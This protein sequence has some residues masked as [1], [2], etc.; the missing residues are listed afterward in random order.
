MKTLKKSLA[1]LLALVMV[2][3]LMSVGV[4][5]ETVTL[6]DDS[7]ETDAAYV[8]QGAVAKATVNGETTYYS[9]LQEALVASWDG[10]TVDVLASVEVNEWHMNLYTE[11][12]QSSAGTATGPLDLTING[13]GNK[14]VI[15]GFDENS[16]NNGALIIRQYGSERPSI[17][18][19]N[20]WTIEVPVGSNTEG[21]GINDRAEFVN[22]TFK[23]GAYGMNLLKATG[24][25]LLQN[26]NFSGQSKAAFY[27]EDTKDLTL[28]DCTFESNFGLFTT[29]DGNI[30]VTGCY[31]KNVPGLEVSRVG[32]A[33]KGNITIRGNDLSGLKM[34]AWNGKHDTRKDFALDLSDNYWGGGAPVY[35]SGE[36]NSIDTTTGALTE[37]IIVDTYYTKKTTFEEYSAEKGW[38]E[39]SNPVS[40]KVAQVN[41][42][43]KYPTLAA[44]IAAANADDTVKLLADVN[45]AITIGKSITLDLNGHNISANGTVVNI[46]AG[47]VV[48][49]NTSDTPNDSTHNAIIPSTKGS[50]LSASGAGTTVTINA[51]YFWGRN[52]NVT[53]INATDD[54]E[55]TIIDCVSNGAPADPTLEGNAGKEGK[56]FYSGAGDEWG[57][58]KN[59]TDSNATPTK[60]PGQ[61]FVYGGT[62]SGRVSDSNWGQYKI[63]GGTFDR[64]TVVDYED[65]QVAN[66]KNVQVKKSVDSGNTITLQEAGWLAE[67]YTAYQTG[68]S[69]WTVAPTGAYVAQVGDI[70]YPTLDAAV[71]AVPDNGTATTIKLLT[72]F[73]GELHSI[74]HGK[75]ITIDAQQNTFTMTYAPGVRGNLTLANGTFKIEDD[76]IY[77]YGLANDNGNT[78]YSKLTVASDATLHSNKWAIVMWHGGDGKCYDAVVDVYGTVEGN[79][80]VS[81]NNTSGDSVINIYPDAT[82]T[83]AVEGVNYA[84]AIAGN[85]FATINITG[86]TI[87]GSE[88]GVEARAGALNISGSPVITGNGTQTIIEANGSGTTT[89]GA[90]VAV[91]QHTT[92]L[93]MNV[94]I[95]GTPVIT[96]KTGL[97]IANPQGNTI[98]NMNV[99]VSGGTFNGGVVSASYDETTG[100]AVKNSDSRVSGFLTGGTFSTKPEASYIADGYAA[101]KSGN[102][103]VVGKVTNTGAT[104]ATTE[105][106]ALDELTT[107]VGYTVETEVKTDEQANAISESI[108]VNV[109]GSTAAEVAKTGD[110]AIDT[111]SNATDAVG[112]MALNQI[113]STQ[114]LGEVVKEAI[115]ESPETADTI[116]VKLVV[117]AEDDTVPVGYVSAVEVHPEAI[118]SVGNEVVGSTK[119]GNDKLAANATFQVTLT[120]PAS[121]G[122]KVRAIHAWEQYTD[123][124]GTVHP[125]GRESLG[126]YEA[127]SPVTIPMSHFSTILFEGVASA[128][129]VNVAVADYDNTNLDKT[130]GV[131]NDTNNDSYYEITRD[132][133]T[134]ESSKYVAVA[135]SADTAY[136]AL[137]TTL[138]YD[139]N[140]LT[141]ENV[142]PASWNFNA[143]VQ[144]TTDN[145]VT[146]TATSQ[147]ATVSA[148]TV[149]AYVIFQVNSDD[150]A[151][152]LTNFTLSNSTVSLQAEGASEPANSTQDSV[153]IISWYT[154]TFNSNGGS[155]VASQTVRYGGVAD[156][157]VPPTK[158]GYTFKHWS[159]TEGGAAYSFNS[160]V[161]GNTTL[162]AVWQINQYT[163]TFN[164]NG[165]S[166][167]AAITQD[168]G[169]AVTAPADPER[170]G[171]NFLG[172]TTDG[173]MVI[174]LPTAMPAD[175]ITY[176]AK[177][178]P[179]TIKLTFVAGDGATVTLNNTEL[180]GE[181]YVTYDGEY[182]ELP[183][184]TLTGNTFGGWYTGENGTGTQIQ[185]DDEV[186][187]A[188]DTTLYAK[189]TPY[190]IS[191]TADN[192][193]NLV[194]DVDITLVPPT[195][196]Y[197]NNDG[198]TV[199]IGTA[200]VNQ[201]YAYKLTFTKDNATLGTRDV[202]FDGTSA[203]LDIDTI[204]ADAGEGASVTVKL[205]KTLKTDNIDV[206]IISFIDANTTYGT[207][208][209]YL[210]T[211]KLP[212]A[213]KAGDSIQYTYTPTDA[214]ESATIEMYLDKLYGDN[215]YAVMIRKDDTFSLNGETSAVENIIES[216]I[217]NGLSL[218]FAS[219]ATTH[220]IENNYDTNRSNTVD[221][222]DVANAFQGVYG[223]IGSVNEYMYIY[224][225]SDVQTPGTP[226]KLNIANVSAVF[227]HY[228]TAEEELAAVYTPPA[229]NP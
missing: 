81:G 208:A 45:E 1:L 211:A 13:H 217:K 212:A 218:K 229:S 220:V 189:W 123:A 70:C 114:K 147:A 100:V 49:D 20:N 108:N 128:Y 94:N 131:L 225:H 64:N 204:I 183:D 120:T 187:L 55:V 192:S 207:S 190:T 24:K 124:A 75:D 174:V 5:A 149:A 6:T 176:I 228:A 37:S 110:E 117:V 79:I 186:K 67:G 169:S 66:A 188:V 166:A 105:T 223:T 173:N 132:D 130:G 40:T 213:L 200:D 82:V 71:A 57:G 19:I 121:N 221:L 224:L 216:T 28:K 85:G 202:T 205:T 25:V 112:A 155:N 181:F 63:Y 144:S 136:R 89:Q 83:T 77:V 146:I 78:P 163:L 140:V 127:N 2:M 126:V 125:A 135:L 201:N 52:G 35:Y 161:N 154:V 46:T 116:G 26:C 41:S 29:A 4:F 219:D 31:F 145:S 156:E 109:T 38:F 179:K 150:M 227:N 209:W 153:E 72:T 11:R 101:V 8:A 165:G 185:E 158:T 50:G 115:Q 15:K 197:G 62:F 10:G 34:T 58:L 90:G 102:V 74:A 39:L 27:S 172:W 159:L 168:Y 76:S 43:T 99:S 91:A 215:V 182:P 65:Q 143:T 113:A 88:T 97:S 184:A 30:T 17:L 214:D 12:G 3:S 95:S 141:Y 32:T 107:S 195:A 33:I 93:Q 56:V 137:G 80:F 36:G 98:K 86:G 119:V 103:Y 180:N 203:T 133:I 51:G 148:N 142:V 171:Y 164:S 59:A 167:V 22:V 210:L 18:K 199:T 157:P 84:Q 106:T 69:E 92:R 21:F 104:T 222:T 191:L 175:N 73:T 7:E 160:P 139:S 194:S 44:A 170:T 47:N 16:V 196:T 48:I 152:G 162:L 60:T 87:T 118:V 14:L 226:A 178:S 42:G 134:E 151:L 193:S 111:G 61:I 53:A 54:A 96:G 9:T 122:G 206:N 138:T 198:L 68:E 129:T 177:W 23:N